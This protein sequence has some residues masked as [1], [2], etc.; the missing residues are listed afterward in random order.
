MN[1]LDTPHKSSRDRCLPVE[2]KG[3]APVEGLRDEP[4]GV[5]D[6]CLTM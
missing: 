5:D 3:K 4:P 6:F 1:L 2:S